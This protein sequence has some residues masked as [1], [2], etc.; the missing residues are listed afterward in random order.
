MLPRYSTSEFVDLF[1]S[2]I[3]PR[4]TSR[5]RR[6]GTPA[7]RGK[8]KREFVAA[9]VKDGADEVALE[10]QIAKLEAS[11]SAFGHALEAITAMSDARAKKLLR[12]ENQR[13]NPVNNP[14]EEA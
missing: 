11:A 14:Q 8:F 7:D 6:P 2:A 3:L 5:S 1:A 9:L 10:R 12:D 4:G 13:R